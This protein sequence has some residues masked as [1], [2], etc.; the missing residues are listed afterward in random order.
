M[1]HDNGPDAPVIR[2][3]PTDI[4]VFHHDGVPM[5]P[6]ETKVK[7]KALKKTMTAHDQRHATQK[8]LNRMDTR[9]TLGGMPQ[10]QA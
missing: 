6:H 8:G 10:G 1:P 3:R 9:A 5:I 4:I 7:A 2:N